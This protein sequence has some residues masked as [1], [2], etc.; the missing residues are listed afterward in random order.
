MTS[1]GLFPTG[2]MA[3]TRPRDLVS[4][5]RKNEQNHPHVSTVRADVPPYLS[6]CSF[7]NIALCYKISNC[8]LLAHPTHL[9]CLGRLSRSFLPARDIHIY[10]CICLP[11]KLWCRQD[12]KRY[13]HQLLSKKLGPRKSWKMRMVGI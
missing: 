12:K 5:Q 6:P 2:H 7:F 13:T 4:K 8:P 11:R 1:V 9:A 10:S 3:V